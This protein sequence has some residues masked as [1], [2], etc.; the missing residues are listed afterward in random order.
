MLKNKVLANQWSIPGIYNV[1]KKVNGKASWKS[2]FNQKSIW[3]NLE[4]REWC[5]GNLS[6][7]GTKVAEIRTIGNQGDKSPQDVPN[8]RWTYHDGKEFWR[9][10]SGD[11]NFE[12]I[13]SET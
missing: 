8:N 4:Y 10:E 13:G 11:V 7:I 2:T 1:Y 9:A 5:I 3:Y 12:C 6:D